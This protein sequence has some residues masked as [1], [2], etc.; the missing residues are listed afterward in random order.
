VRRK[1]N[2][3]MLRISPKI[4]FR[5]LLIFVLSTALLLALWVNAQ[6]GGC[7]SNGSSATRQADNP[8]D[9]LAKP[10][11]FD[12]WGC[13]NCTWS[14]W[15]R[16]WKIT[17]GDLSTTN[18]DVASHADCYASYFSFTSPNH[19]QPDFG[20]PTL[21]YTTDANHMTTTTWSE[22]I[23]SSVYHEGTCSTAY[24]RTQLYTTSE[25]CDLYEGI[26]TPGECQAAG[27]YWNFTTSACQSTSGCSPDGPGPADCEQGVQMWCER[28]CMCTATQAQCD[29]SPII[30]DVTG[31]GLSLLRFRAETGRFVPTRSCGASNAGNRQASCARAV[32]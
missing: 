22:V 27:G 24:G 2:R 8:G 26:G 1:E 6:A 14:I 31:N 5:R 29:S 28:R 30:V 4:T 9:C 18:I 32:C 19:C 17:W 10:S 3:L 20:T 13:I 21:T 11:Q 16:Y 25:T 7:G 23:V 12:P 15:T